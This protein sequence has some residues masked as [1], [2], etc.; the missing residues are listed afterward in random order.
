[1]GLNCA[2]LIICGVFSVNTIVQYDLKL[3]EYMDIELL[4]RTADS[5]YTWIFDC[6]R[7]D[8]HN[9]LLFKGQV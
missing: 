9:H 5:S 6:V 4:I 8:A 2:D 3:V 7:I 1:M